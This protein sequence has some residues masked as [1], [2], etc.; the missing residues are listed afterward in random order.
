MRGFSALLLLLMFSAPVLSSSFEVT[1]ITSSSE[2]N[3]YA[4]KSFSG[5]TVKQQRPVRRAVELALYESSTLF[6][7]V[8]IK[9]TLRELEIDL[10]SDLSAQ[11]QSVS[12]PG[13]VILDL[14]LEAMER[15]A[16]LTDQMNVAA[17][18]VR[19][20]DVHLRDALCLKNLFHT[21]PSDRMYFDALGQWA[22]TAR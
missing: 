18:N 6:E 14:P 9:A 11:L 17:F 12:L 4:G 3:Q 10:G 22:F 16:R 1:V 8:G 13:I 15:V 19:H 5:I 21:I 2:D 7:T 20:R